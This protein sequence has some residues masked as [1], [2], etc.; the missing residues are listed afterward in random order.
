M[1]V[2]ME[3]A[4]VSVREF[5][6]AVSVAITEGKAGD[7]MAPVLVW[8]PNSE[9][10]RSLSRAVARIS[11]AVN[12]RFVTGRQLATMLIPPLESLPRSRRLSADLKRELTRT[13]ARHARPPLGTAA[14]PLL[15]QELVRAFDELRVM[16]PLEVEG[17]A[18]LGPLQA[19]IVRLFNAYRELGALFHDDVD[20]FEAARESV[21]AASPFVVVAGSTST[22]PAEL[23]LIDALAFAGRLSTVQLRDATAEMAGLSAGQIVVAPDPSAEVHN[24]VSAVLER[25]SSGVKLPQIAVVHGGVSQYAT[26]LQ[27]SLDEAGIPWRGRS[28]RTL[29]Q[30]ICG[31]VLLTLAEAVAA[32]LTRD[33][34]LEWLSSGPICLQAAGDEL[35][36]VDLWSRAIK[37]VRAT[38]E[39]D[40]VVQRAKA[41][42]EHQLARFISELRESVPASHA[43]WDAWVQ[44]A[45]S[46]VSRYLG[47]EAV[48]RNWPDQERIVLAKTL[49]GIARMRRLDDIGCPVESAA[50]AAA[51]SDELAATVSR[52]NVA[53]GVFVGRWSDMSHCEF[54]TVIAVGLGDGVIE[55]T[56]GG[57]VASLRIPG[58][59]TNTDTSRAALVRVLAN[60]ESRVLSCSRADTRAGRERRPSAL[61]VDIA[62]QWANAPVSASKLV[63][64]DSQLDW[65]KVIPSFTSLINS[66]G[67]L[68]NAQFDEL[69]ALRA[70]VEDPSLAIGFEFARKRA[71]HEFT[72]F[73]GATQPVELP[74]SLAPTSLETWATCPYRFF[75]KHMLGLPA[76]EM[77]DDPWNL[78]AGDRGKLI[79]E[80]LEEFI[81]TAAPLDSPSTPWPASERARLHQL[82]DAKFLNARETGVAPAGILL[83]SEVEMIHNH[84]DVL[85]DDDEVMRLE[86]GVVPSAG[87]VEVTFD[88][89]H[90]ERS[91]AQPVVFHGRIDRVD[92]S[93]TGGRVRAIDYKTGRARSVAK[94]SKDPVDGGRRLQLGVYASALAQQATDVCAA[95]WFITDDQATERTNEIEW[96]DETE[97]RLREVVSAM[98]EGV[99]NGVFPAVPGPDDDKTHKNCRNC[100]YDPI[101]PVDR[102]EAWARKS[103]DAA[104]EPFLRLQ[105]GASDE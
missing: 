95:Y 37:R 25:A 75:L 11:G 38:N 89:L 104:V 100:P 72:R 20:L 90:V 57:L 29:G 34:F 102:S 7:V 44:W 69:A 53:N 52:P 2:G 8:V 99:E 3:V 105:T 32:G 47:N 101:C 35:V 26:L 30:S 91:D 16:S 78:A 5:A 36:P 33:S 61:A 9:S 55:R 21:S 94:L 97:E 56:T 64:G 84:L 4:T 17:V 28:T 103:S 54:D 15:V 65:L 85:L 46:C 77:Q 22:N 40:D 93:P 41:N 66:D 6:N 49:D 88:S 43:T 86:T 45:T 79:H 74:A 62:S 67:L 31:R 39:I 50:F 80:V 12:V 81:R 98:A 42:G 96:N 76:G 59:E 83:E 10:A 48:V 27:Q 68:P 58:A 13:V 87:G 92:K 19:E 14:S 70:G 73:D 60:C 24:A 82:A 51:L 18:D 63:S 1:V 71:S 23:A